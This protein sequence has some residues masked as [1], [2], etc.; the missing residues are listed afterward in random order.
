MSFYLKVIEKK[1]SSKL[2]ENN[3]NKSSVLVMLDL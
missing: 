1:L 3:Y 2:Y